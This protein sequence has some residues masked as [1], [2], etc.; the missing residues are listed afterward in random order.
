MFSHSLCSELQHIRN[1]YFETQDLNSCLTKKEKHDQFICLTNLKRLPLDE[2]QVPKFGTY[3]EPKLVIQSPI[4]KSCSE[5]L[6]T[7]TSSFESLTSQKEMVRKILLQI[8]DDVPSM[9][10]YSLYESINL[11]TKEA[12]QPSDILLALKVLDNK[13]LLCDS[14]KHPYITTDFNQLIEHLILYLKYN[15]V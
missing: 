5:V 9:Q 6:A 1:F 11:K 12:Y 8:H 2:E 4:P 14:K 13:M 15:N 7:S 3:Y 10:L